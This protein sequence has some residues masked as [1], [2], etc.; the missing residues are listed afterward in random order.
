METGGIKD[1]E[2]KEKENPHVFAWHLINMNR[3]HKLFLMMSLEDSFFALKLSKLSTLAIW[4]HG[5]FWQLTSTDLQVAKA[6]L[7]NT[8]LRRKAVQISYKSLQLT[9]YNC[10]EREETVE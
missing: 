10:L 5:K 9:S 3:A 6:V 1:Q 7:K 4:R 2:I 8:A